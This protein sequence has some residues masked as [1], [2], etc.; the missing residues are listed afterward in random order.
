MM[1]GRYLSEKDFY[2]QLG[3]DWKT[4]FKEA[5]PEIRRTPDDGVY[6]NVHDFRA[7]YVGGFGEKGWL[8]K[9][10]NAP[11]NKKEF[12]EGLFPDSTGIERKLD[13]QEKRWIDGELHTLK[14]LQQLH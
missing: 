1:N 2:R 12:F 6:R 5:R 11:R 10:L 4:K 9:W 7:Y 13:K 8:E 14:D 3:N